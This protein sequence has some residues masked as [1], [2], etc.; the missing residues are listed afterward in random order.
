MLIVVVQLNRSK[1]NN[2]ELFRYKKPKKQR[3]FV[4][5]NKWAFSSKLTLLDIQLK[6]KLSGK[7]E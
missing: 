2:A 7:I 4:T 1:T 6:I 3:N 5:V